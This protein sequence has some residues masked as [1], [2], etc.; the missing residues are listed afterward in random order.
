MSQKYKINTIKVIKNQKVKSKG[1]QKVVN[2]FSFKNYRILLILLLS[3]L[4]VYGNVLNGPMF[5]DDEHFIQKN[6]HVHNL[7]IKKIYSRSVTDGASMP[8]NF[9]R[10]NQQLVYAIVY[11]F[12]GE[13]SL[14]YH[15]I[16][17]ILHILNAYFV[18]LIAS[19]LKF[20]KVSA[21]IAAFFFLLHPVQTEAVSYISGL[22][23]P[24]SLC[25]LL[26]GVFFMLKSFNTESNN[27]YIKN[28]IISIIF[29]ILALFTKENMV[30]LLPLVIIVIIVN[31][32]LN[33]NEINKKRILIYIL[34][35]LIIVSIYLFLKF[36][37]FTF[38]DYKG[39]TSFSNSYTKN[40]HIRILTFISVLWDYFKMLV[41]PVPLHYEKP[42]IAYANWLTWRAAFGYSVICL[43]IF[44]CIKFR[45]YPYL[46][47]AVA[48]F[49]AALFPFTGIVPLNA[50]Y[51]EHWLY[52]PII[53][54]SFSIALIYTKIKY[55]NI[56][57]LLLIP[58]FLFYSIR[59]IIRNT[60]WSD[61][62]KFY[63]KELQYSGNALRIYNNLGLY[64]ANIAEKNLSNKQKFYNLNRKA[65]KYYRKAIEIA[66]I[67]PQPYHNI[68]N[69]YLLEGKV[70]EAFNQF[71][72]ALSIDPSFIYSH[73]KIAEIYQKNSDSERA[74]KF[75]EF[76]QR[77]DAGEK[78]NFSEIQKAIITEIE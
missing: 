23:D 66:E 1:I 77:A 60:E 40:L 26:S 68:G 67:Y 10:P 28:T 56:F 39:L 16:S 73:L 11:H 24:L 54:V 38:S 32:I 52:V 19:K 4:I 14:P 44:I 36:T 13:Y 59:V 53:G 51:L 45:K 58:L 50:M 22:A 57:I 15:L 78:I 62:E 33:K 61:V 3:G 20:S 64:Y 76:A 5:F 31:N 48:W 46:F 74:K 6:K 35:V 65:E 55:K 25:F 9:Y 18:F 29:F 17:I 69:I 47:L 37:V 42:Y 49:F 27:L 12:S 8:S 2:W 72:F 70:H 63:L 75:I 34:S 43:C 30:V 7:D 71:I 21:L 41:Y